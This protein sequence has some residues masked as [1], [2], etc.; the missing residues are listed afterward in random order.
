MNIYFDMR[1]GEKAI[2]EIKNRV[3]LKSS[4]QRKIG[5]SKNSFH[6]SATIAAMATG[7]VERD[8]HYYRLSFTYED[9]RNDHW[10]F[11]EAK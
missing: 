1:K 4:E 6:M 3:Y 8:P 10:T 11:S 5:E 2:L 7:R 9:V